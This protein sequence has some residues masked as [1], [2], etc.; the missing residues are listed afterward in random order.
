MS[1]FKK[2]L[3]NFKKKRGGKAFDEDPNQLK[4]D[5]PEKG[6][7]AI[8]GRFLMPDDEELG[9][10]VTT[11]RHE[12]PQG[13]DKVKFWCPRTF[14]NKCSCCNYVRPLWKEGREDDYRAWSAKASNYALFLVTDHP[15]N[16]EANG[17]VFVLTFKKTIADKL[18]EYLED[19][20]DSPAYNIFDLD[21]G[22]EF[23]LKVRMK[24]G[25]PNYDDSVFIPT[26]TPVAKEH[27]HICEN[28]GI[29]LAHY[30]QRIKE[31]VKEDHENVDKFEELTGIRV[32]L[33]SDSKVPQK[34]KEAVAKASEA[35][36][37][38]EAPV[39]EAP[40]VEAKP[41]PQRSKPISEEEPEELP[42]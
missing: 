36:A 19:T 23:Y 34:A 13:D 17:K 31:Y 8:K 27:R 29:D 40:K 38:S 16:P 1:A 5:T 2:N 4:Y 9:F 12:I 24:G 14:G 18:A 15:Q 28:H 25:W 6:V 37:E 10:Y 30:T 3:Q 32:K 39:E 35:H 22:Y 20:E 7:L 42:F 26:P 21:T 33:I 11:L 41:L